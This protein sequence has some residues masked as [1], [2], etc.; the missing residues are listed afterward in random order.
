MDTVSTIKKLIIGRWL[1]TD[2]DSNSIMIISKDSIIGGFSQDCWSKY[3]IKL[4][5]LIGKNGEAKLNEAFPNFYAVFKKIEE[6]H[7]K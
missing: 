1:E 7:N 3:K 2:G 4:E 6:E 5:K